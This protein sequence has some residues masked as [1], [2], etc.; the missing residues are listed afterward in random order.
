LRF[1]IQ[2]RDRPGPPVSPTV[3]LHPD[4]SQD[5]RHRLRRQQPWWQQ[6]EPQAWTAPRSNLRALCQRIR[7]RQ[8]RTHPRQRLLRRTRRQDAT[9]AG[10]PGSWCPA[11]SDGHRDLGATPLNEF[12][13]MCACDGRLVRDVGPEHH[14]L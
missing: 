13:A 14:P 8:S 3:A 9:D 7:S 12:S 2:T 4:Q 10:S 5:G 11:G 6:E 1:P